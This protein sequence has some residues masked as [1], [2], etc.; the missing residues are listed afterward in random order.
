MKLTN[1]REPDREA[2]KAFYSAPGQ[3]WSW[4]DMESGAI[5][6][7]RIATEW[8][9]T[10]PAPKEYPVLLPRVSVGPNGE[11]NLFW[12]AIAFNQTQSEQLRSELW[13]FLGPVATD[14]TRR[15]AEIRVDDEAEAVLLSWCGGPWIYRFTVIDNSKKDW[16]R[17]ALCR[18]RFIWTKRPTT[19]QTRFRTTE[20]LLRDFHTALVNK[21][22]SSSETWLQELRDGGRLSAENLLFLQVERLAAFGRW[23]E[24]F[25]HPQWSLLRQLRRP[26]QVTARM[27]EALCLVKLIPFVDRN[28][29]QGVIKYVRETVLPENG[30]LFRNRGQACSQHILL[31]FYLTAAASETP[32]RD[33]VEKLLL[34]IPEP[35]PERRFAESV[36]SFIAEATTKPKESGL[37]LARRAIANNDY[38][39]AWE[40][41]QSIP[42]SVDSTRML[43]ICAYEF[44]SVEAA[45]VVNTTLESLVERDRSLVFT[46]NRG[47]LRNWEELKK[48]LTQTPDPT[49]WE[50]WLEQLD[51]KSD[52]T[53]A[54]SVASAGASMWSLDIYRGNPNRVG[55]FAD[56]LFVDRSDPARRSLRSA[57][58][59][60]ASFFI[61]E[62]QGLS[63]YRPIYCNLLMLTSLN[64]DFGTE[65]FQFVE[66][67]L[68]AIFEAGVTR[69]IY[70]DAVQSCTE[71][72]ETHGSVYTINWA[73]EILDILASRQSP[74]PS[75]RDAFFE[76][77]RVTFQKEHRRISTSQWEMFSWLSHD[78][79]RTPD[80][81]AIRSPSSIVDASGA[82]CEQ[83]RDVLKGQTV[84][85]YTLTE[86]AGDRA[87]KI[88]QQMFAEVEVLVNS[89]SV[90]SPALKSLSR[91]A[92]WFLVSTRSAK[93]A[94]TEFIKENRPTG[95]SELLYPVGK[96]ASSIVGALLRAIASNS[97]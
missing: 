58:P 51:L 72:W 2:L 75:I 11:S 68:E 59:H 43:L 85:I 69:Q 26:R 89:D 20:E 95:K 25:L 77:V 22:D 73:L 21:D 24:L 7:A 6:A 54:I 10:G 86:S 34:Q 37:E 9:E 83:N 57:L 62:N 42:P 80:F 35:T 12:Y 56:R 19:L 90:G 79:G 5:A 23:E 84:A 46:N 18:L 17:S 8:V 81:A 14:F 16:L 66:T 74:L 45:Q 97:F 3:L 87:K 52:W 92:D 67:L 32:Q 71:I 30:A 33:R 78:L 38:E 47:I 39:A 4:S 49:D 29:A 61:P 64:D 15:C 48:R 44:D 40:I 50:S 53:E 94:A 31:A 65:D 91:R 93:H 60:L 55:K 13:A 63:E 82:T 76:V 96:G 1:W 27:I 88:I 41:L 28:D 36:F 70:Q